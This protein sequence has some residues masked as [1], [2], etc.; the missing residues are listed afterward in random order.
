MVTPQRLELI[1][2]QVAEE[3]EHTWR[4]KTKKHEAEIEEY[5]SA[6][7][8]LRYELS[9]LKAEYEHDSAENQKRLEDMA[10]QHDLEVTY[11]RLH[12]SNFQFYSF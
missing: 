8:R 3:V 5:R 2:T 9:F 1:R 6:T 12:S 7:S 4:E 10:K 11:H